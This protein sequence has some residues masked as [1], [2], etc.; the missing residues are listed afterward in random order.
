MTSKGSAK[1][2][3]P[4]AVDLLVK[5]LKLSSMITTP[6]QDGV[7][8]PRGVG[9]NELKIIMCLGG[10]GAL[11]GHDITEIMAMP[12]MNVSRALAT[13]RE[14]GWIEDVV[15]LENRRRK[16]VQLSKAGAAASRTMMPDVGVVAE[17]LLGKLGR[18]ERTMLA[19][20]SDKIAARMADWIVEHHA[21][22]KLRR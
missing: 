16:P 21:E 5:L 15:D 18:N 6:M 19:K 2:A 12:P 20:V 7:A 10:E 13:L 8:E 3:G 9:V 4:A 1:E 11:A 22:V 14:R 17:Y